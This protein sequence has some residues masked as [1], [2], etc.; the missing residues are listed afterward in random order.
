MFVHP[1]II[2]KFI[3]KN[4]TR[5]NNVSKCYYSIFIWSSICFGRHTAH[6]QEPK[7]PLAASGFSYVEGCWTC[8]WWT[9]SGTLCL[10]TSTIYTSNNLPRMKNQRLPVEFKA[11][12]DGRC[13]ARNI[14]SFI[15][16]WNNKILIH[17]CILLDFS[18]STIG[19]VRQ[20]SVELPQCQIHGNPLDRLP[21]QVIQCLKSAPQNAPNS[22]AFLLTF[23]LKTETDQV[24]ETLRSYR[25][26]DDGQSPV[27]L[28]SNYGYAHGQP[29]VR[30]RSTHGHLT[31][32]E[33]IS[34]LHSNG[35]VHISTRTHIWE[36]WRE[37]L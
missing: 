35:S 11:P 10:T 6:H 15:W 20:I 19:V 37:R 17:C 2:V 30:S 21:T 18:L 32:R 7:T 8:S 31:D 4:P 13:V 24:T 22:S 3:K 34:F 28:D 14:L 5:S 12:D 1:C 26:P 36:Q 33:N 9:L 29:M 16:I 27:G 23:R 25:I